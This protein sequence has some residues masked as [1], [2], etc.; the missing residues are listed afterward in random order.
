MFLLVTGLLLV[1]AA[2]AAVRMRRP[3]E[4]GVPEI[5]VYLD[6]ENQMYVRAMVAMYKN[7]SEVAQYSGEEDNY[8]LVNWNLVDK[9]ALSAEEYRSQLR[10]ELQEGKGPDLVFL[11][12]YS[13]E[14]PAE[15]VEQ[16]YLAGLDGWLESGKSV[17][18]ASDF[19]EG[20]LESG[21]MDGE[22]Y[23]IPVSVDLPVLVTT[24]ERLAQAG[25]TEEELWDI[26]RLFEVAA[27]YQEQTGESPFDSCDFLER[28]EQYIGDEADWSEE[29]RADVEALKAGVSGQNR[30]EEEDDRR[31]GEGFAGD[32]KQAEEGSVEDGRQA[33]EDFAEDGSD[34]RGT[35]KSSLQAGEDSAAGTCLFLT[36]GIRDYRRMAVQ[37]AMLPEEETVVF[38]PLRR[39]DGQMQAVLRQAVAVNRH[40]SNL[41]A[42]YAALNAFFQKRQ[43]NCAV[44]LPVAKA[45]DWTGLIEQAVSLV[46]FG[47][48]ETN[49]LGNNAG[50]RY[51]KVTSKLVETSYCG[52]FPLPETSCGG[53]VPVSETSCSEHVPVSETSC[54]EY[55]PVSE[56]SCSEYVPLLETSCS[57]RSSVSEGECAGTGSEKALSV[58]VPDDGLGEEGPLY[59]WIIGAAE[60]FEAEHGIHV[61]VCRG[62]TD[63]WY[64]RLLLMD[65]A[66]DITVL[67][68]TVVWLGYEDTAE[69]VL[70]YRPLLDESGLSGLA[71]KEGALEAGEQSALMHIPYL[72]ET[73]LVSGFI[74]SAKTEL[75][76]EALEFIRLCLSR[77]EYEK[78][79]ARI[80]E[81]PVLMREAGEKSDSLP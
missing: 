44:N 35:A 78:M 71:W 75:P 27:A 68:R 43:H 53:Q 3:G 73:T 17:Y 31:T 62:E 25:V 54:G 69:H 58:M 48:Q 8:P 47:W 5:T 77:D 55:V 42:A 18:T 12:A 10:S 52:N 20:I 40:S 23:L 41:E 64:E 11:D 26:E 63:E 19:C 13:C 56:T 59:E 76:E 39:L 7:L 32:G 9:S 14:D 51:A 67:Y 45:Y 49:S 1:L 36:A 70:D 50:W 65:T 21:Q 61:E 28:L 37:A 66:A 38:L 46:P 24:Q 60:E 81:E 16:G 6:R 33:E 79:A 34:V 72:E 30:S 22:Q 57:E 80:G 4:K 74:V 2:A 15:F 29:L